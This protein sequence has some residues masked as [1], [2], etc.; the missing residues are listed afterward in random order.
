MLK[1]Y[2]PFL[3]VVTVVVACN[4]DKLKTTPS[5]KLKSI[6][7]TELFPGQDL[8][9]GLEYKDKEGDLGTGLITYIR[10][11]LNAKPIPD[12]ASNDKA[13]T[14]TSPLPDFP[15][16]TT[17]DIELR[18]VNGFLSEDPFDNDT[19]TFKIFVKDLA[20]HTSDTLVTETI[21]ERQN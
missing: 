5:L 16:T 21:V 17:G 11:R 1:R 9:I 6:N 3:L 20:G 18:I 2:L 10:N 7:S 4:K 19:M 15:K 8:V 13:D 14:I 12:A